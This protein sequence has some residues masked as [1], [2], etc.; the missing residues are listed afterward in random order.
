LKIYLLKPKSVA[1]TSA[2]KIGQ[3]V[4]VFQAATGGKLTDKEQVEADCEL[5][6]LANERNI[7]SCGGCLPDFV[8]RHEENGN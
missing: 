1:V 2:G 6:V 4:I 3:N 7:R 5:G 8:Q